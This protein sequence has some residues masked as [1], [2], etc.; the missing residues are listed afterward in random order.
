LAAATLQCT[1][2]QAAT[3]GFNA[4]AWRKRLDICFCNLFCTFQAIIYMSSNLI[5]LLSFSKVYCIEEDMNR[6]AGSN[7]NVVLNLLI[8]ENYVMLCRASRKL[9]THEFRHRV[10]VFK[11]LNFPSPHS[12]L[13]EFPFWWDD[14]SNWSS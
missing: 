11:I 4:S 10:P 7:Q 14:V 2:D 1:K 6:V 12:A 13:P 3:S 8:F 9:K 5:D